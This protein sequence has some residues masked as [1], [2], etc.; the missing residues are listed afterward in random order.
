MK[1]EDLIIDPLEFKEWWNPRLEYLLQY[2]PNRIGKLF[3]TNR[4][5]LYAELKLAVQKAFLYEEK[6]S[7]NKN[8]AP[9]QIEEIVLNMVAPTEGEPKEPLPESLEFRIRA[10]AQDPPEAKKDRARLNKT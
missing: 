6:V 1:P 8:L 7:E 5:A 9:D 10:W 4:K 2:E 3:R